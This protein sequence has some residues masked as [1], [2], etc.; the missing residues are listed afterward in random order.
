MEGNDKLKSS[1]WKICAK[2]KKPKFG[3]KKPFLKILDWNLKKL[4]SYLKST[5]SNLSKYQKLSKTATITTTTESETK[6]A[7][8]G[9]F[10]GRIFKNLFSYLKSALS[11][12]SNCK[13]CEET[14]ISKFATKKALFGYF[15]EQIL[16]SYCGIWNRH[17]QTCQLQN[18]AE[19]QKC[20]NLGF[21]KPG[22]LK[23]YYHIWNL[24]PQI[25]QKMIFGIGFAFSKN[26][27]STFSE[28]PGPRRDP[29]YKVCCFMY[30]CVRILYIW[31]REIAFGK[32]TKYQ[33]NYGMLLFE[34]KCN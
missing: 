14:K 8:F 5:P 15:W 32:W 31:K 20:V 9:Y 10:W 3:P 17:P 7:L 25:C 13:F 27:G 2:I 1:K 22:I 30:L 28:G 29:L 24:H 11:N 26:P 34:K 21:Q 18:F 4:M 6:I 23:T 19:K 12:L 33:S 16:E